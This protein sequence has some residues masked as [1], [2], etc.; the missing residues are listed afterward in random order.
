MN[1]GREADS[2]SI[3]RIY[4]KG[5]EP[6]FEIVQWSPVISKPVLSIQLFDS[7]LRQRKIRKS[8]VYSLDL[9]TKR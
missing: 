6:R 4:Q 2:Q 9:K 1:L 8:T 5:P 7:Y 3:Y